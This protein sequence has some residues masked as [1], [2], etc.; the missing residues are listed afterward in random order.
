MATPRLRISP[1]GPLAVD[2]SPFNEYAGNIYS[3]S[4]TSTTEYVG[5][6]G[7]SDAAAPFADAVTLGV[8][9]SVGLPDNSVHLPLANAEP[10]TFGPGLWLVE[11]D[12]G[13]GFATAP[14]SADTF[15]DLNLSA[16]FSTVAG[17]NIGAAVGHLASPLPRTGTGTYGGNVVHSTKI[18]FVLEVTDAMVAANGNLPVEALEIT[19]SRITGSVNGAYTTTSGWLEISKDT[20]VKVKRFR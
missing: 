11:L 19:L 1:S 6:I 7:P 2:Q 13:I 14:A 12:L 9:N 5:K 20:T 16:Q 10:V 4:K 3:V 18:D 17:V 8:G 15:A